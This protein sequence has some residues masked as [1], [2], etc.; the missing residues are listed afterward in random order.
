[1]KDRLVQQAYSRLNHRLCRAAR[2]G[3]SDIQAIADYR[4][5]VASILGA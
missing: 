5:V 2:Q 3:E 1:M 4:R